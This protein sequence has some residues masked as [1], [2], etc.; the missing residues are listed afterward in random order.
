MAESFTA[1]N[2]NAF[3]LSIERNT[4]NYRGLPGRRAH[5]YPP[6]KGRSPLT[7]HHDPTK[8]YNAKW[9]QNS[10]Q[11]LLTRDMNSVVVT[12]VLGFDRFVRGRRPGGAREKCTETD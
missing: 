8:Y 7:Q 4:M 6:R 2:F 11:I 1:T 5:T 9:R 12:V 3:Q 10:K